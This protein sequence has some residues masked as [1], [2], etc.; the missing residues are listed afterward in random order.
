MIRRA[1]LLLI[2]GLALAS[3]GYLLGQFWPLQLGGRRDQPTAR[4]ARPQEPRTVLAV[5]QGR[6]LPSGGIVNVYAPQ[7]QIVEEYLFGEPD[8][9]LVGAAVRANEVLV[10][11]VG[12]Q[13][14]EQQERLADAQDIDTT[15][16]LENKV[17]LAEV[18]CLQA[19]LA[20]QQALAQQREVE[21]QQDQS[22]NEQKL[23]AAR[24]RLADLRRLKQDPEV[25]TW[26]SQKKIDDGQLELRQAERELEMGQQRL[27]L[28]LQT[29]QSA[30]E[31]A[32]RNRAAAREALDVARRMLEEKPETLRANKRLAETQLRTSQIKSPI[33]GQVL[34]VLVRPGESVVN[35]PLLQ[36]GNLA[37]MECRV[38]VSERDVES[39]R[40]AGGNVVANLR[41]PALVD[42]QGE[43]LILQGEI[44]EIESIVGDASLPSPN[45]LAMTDKKTVDVIVRIDQPPQAAKRLINLQVEVEFVD[46]RIR[47]QQ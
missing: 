1:S 21:L 29:S 4:D 38:E 9:P 19:D 17:R 8:Q 36:L 46:S 3:G 43:P 34:K 39:L 16:E 30:V 13:L 37:Q 42:G 22:L 35:T 15:L 33:D 27:A 28:A 6:L 5:A 2:S 14:L 25:G 45:P 20:V 7:G 11:L 40:H 26:I 44:L 23:A 41:S 10:K 12:Q 31:A 24:S 18:Q 47:P 32:E